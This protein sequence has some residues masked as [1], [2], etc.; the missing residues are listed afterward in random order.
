MGG[1][2]HEKGVSLLIQSLP[3]MRHLDSKLVVV[4][5]GDE[6]EFGGRAD[7]LGVRDRVIFAGRTPHPERYYAMGDCFTFLSK[8]EGLA[9]VQAEAA[10]SGLPLLLP[11]ELGPSR[12]LEDGVSG[13]RCKYTPESVAQKLDAFASDRDFLRQAGE[14]SHRNSLH[15]SWDNQAD[16]IESILLQHLTP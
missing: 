1:L 8:A 6:D 2:W 14:A 12:L 7:A 15:F 4:G 11:D 13:L 10:A 5:G 9:L 3:R 16:T